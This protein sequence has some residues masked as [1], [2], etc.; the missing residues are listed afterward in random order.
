MQHENLITNASRQLKKH[1]Q[2]Y[3]THDLELAFVVFAL[4]IWRHYIYGDP[5]RIFIDR[6]SL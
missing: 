5:C 4:R 1:D 2:K 3:P 6:K